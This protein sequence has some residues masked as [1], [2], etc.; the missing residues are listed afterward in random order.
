MILSGIGEVF[1]HALYLA[2]ALGFPHLQGQFREDTKLLM[3]QS[4]S[5]WKKS[6]WLVILITCLIMLVVGLLYQQKIDHIQQE[7]DHLKRGSIR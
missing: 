1:V 4:N 2:T 5:L 3:E 6:I 7:M